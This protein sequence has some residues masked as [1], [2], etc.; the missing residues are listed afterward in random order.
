MTEFKAFVDDKMHDFYQLGGDIVVDA[1]GKLLY[2]F[3]SKNS[4]DR[5]SVDELLETIPK[6]DTDPFQVGRHN[7]TLAVVVES[8]GQGFQQRGRSNLCGSCSIM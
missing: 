7:N 5:P 2:V 3:K 4:D 1:K 6:A 8:Q